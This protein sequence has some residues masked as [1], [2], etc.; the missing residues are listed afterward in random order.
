M[1]KW[2]KIEEN[3]GFANVKGDIISI[4]SYG[5]LMLI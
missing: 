3:L 5:S 1:K 4:A 2:Q